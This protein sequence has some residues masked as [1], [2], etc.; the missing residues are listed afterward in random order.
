MTADVKICFYVVLDKIEN[1]YEHRRLD[2][3]ERHDIYSSF[4]KLNSQLFVQ[5]TLT[6]YTTKEVIKIVTET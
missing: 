3:R 6:G 2:L 4:I 5:F 1:Q